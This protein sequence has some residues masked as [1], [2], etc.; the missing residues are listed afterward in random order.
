[1]SEAVRAA[2]ADRIEARRKDRAFQ[3]RI[4]QM[5]EEERAVLDQLAK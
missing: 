5:M 1:V 2:I 3:A 4:K